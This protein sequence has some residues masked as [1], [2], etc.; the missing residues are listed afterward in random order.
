MR[1]LSRRTT[2]AVVLLCGL[3]AVSTLWGQSKGR[4]I[5]RTVGDSYPEVTVNNEEPS[6]EPAA[7]APQAKGQD[8]DKQAKVEERNRLIQTGMQ[9]F[10]QN[11]TQ[12]H[13]AEKSLSRKKSYS[14]WLA[15]IRRM[16]DKDDADIPDLAHREIATYLA[17]LSS[18]N[19]GS[20]NAEVNSSDD[21]SQ[22]NVPTTTVFGTVS[23]LWRGGNEDI[24]NP[25]FF[26]DAWV[27]ISHSGAGPISM[28]VTSCISC[29]NE[30][31]GGFL[32]RL[33]LVE[34]VVRLD[35][36]KLAMGDCKLQCEPTLKSSVEAGRLVVPFGAFASQVNPG[37]YRTVSKPLIF[38]MGQRVVDTEL[39]DPVL[40]M[41]Y[42]DE[43]VNWSSTLSL[44]ERVDASFDAFAVNGLQGGN[45]GVDFDTSRDY[46]DNNKSPSVGGRATI[47]SKQLR[48]GTSLMSGRFN[49]NQGDAPFNQGMFYKLVG[50]DVTFRHQD[51]FR[52]QFEY[53]QRDSDR[54]ASL[55]T[56]TFFRENVGGYYFESELLISRVLKT[57]LLARYDVMTRHSLAAPPEAVV[58]TATDFS[59]RRFTYGLNWNLPGG[60]LLMIN[61]EHWMLP[62]SLHNVDVL[63]VRWAASF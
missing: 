59:M 31:D 6:E 19:A 18:N 40:P 44:T 46:I 43:G 50:A 2:F 49:S 41:P 8:Q 53:A 29:H 5:Q 24:Q 32:S 63:G 26:G 39:G 23:P 21:S 20:E 42:A 54:V 33:E 60:S 17:S 61:H 36:N 48:I 52:F 45:G 14:A 30:S 57:S 13:D 47:G 7:P 4:V 62:G 16:A 22:D 51:I 38:N 10:Q 3:S 56:D 58:N 34:A 11:C 25:G 1:R 12:C 28:R 35:L 55:P 27:G 9:S 37:V 15:T